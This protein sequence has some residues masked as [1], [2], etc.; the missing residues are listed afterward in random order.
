MKLHNLMKE[1]S[2]VSSLSVASQGDITEEEDK[3]EAHIKSAGSEKWAKKSKQEKNIMT[4][5]VWQEVTPTHRRIEEKSFPPPKFDVK[6]LGSKK[7]AGSEISATP[8]ALQISPAQKSKSKKASGKSKTKKQDIKPVAKRKVSISSVFEVEDD[9][10]VLEIQARKKRESDKLA[11]RTKDK[12]KGRMRESISRMA[13]F[14]Q[15]LT[16]SEK[17]NECSKE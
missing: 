5:S 2:D 13:E 4:S 6:Y 15:C 16:G 12:I 10:Y 7:N 17:L 11:M 8:P 14:T 3:F 9:P 1:F